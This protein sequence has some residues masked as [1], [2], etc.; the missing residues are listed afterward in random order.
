MS[1]QLFEI[2]QENEVVDHTAYYYF[3]EKFKVREHPE[4]SLCTLAAYNL[5]NLKDLSD[6]E[7]WARTT[8]RFLDD[9]LS[10]Q[11]YPVKAAEWSTVRRRPL[12]IGVINYAYYLA[13]NGSRYSDES[14]LKLTHELFEAMSFYTMK[15]SV[16]L[17]QERGRCEGFEDLKYA[18]GLLPIDTYKKTI[19]EFANFDYLCDWEWLRGQIKEHGIRNSTLL[20][21]MPSE[22]SSIV[23]NATNGIEPPRSLV[24]TKS[25]KDGT[26]KQ[27]VPEIHRLKN[28]Y[29]MLWEI[30]SMEPVIKLVAVMSKFVD[31]AISTNLSYDKT[32]YDGGIPMKLLLKDYFMTVKYGIKNLYYHNTRD[33]SDQSEKEPAPAADCDSGACAI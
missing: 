10:Y 2:V 13:K 4:I 9:L 21:L 31:Q 28:Q 14:A 22:S 16:E 20:A 8:V 3:H 17:A 5:G 11:K 27:V 29:E 12:G 33:G 6:L 30:P 32:K 25:S 24:A 18:D 23:S 19:D 1:E 15:A 7:G 26:V